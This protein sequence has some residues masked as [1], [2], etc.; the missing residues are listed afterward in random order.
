M[1]DNISEGLFVAKLDTD[2]PAFKAGIRY[3]DIIVSINGKKIDTMLSLR[4]EL[5]RRQGGETVEIEFIRKGSV[6]RVEV[7]LATAN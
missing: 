6:R 2:G 3:A 1:D 5:Y 4:E 7:M